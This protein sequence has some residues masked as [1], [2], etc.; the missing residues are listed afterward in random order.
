MISLT[1]GIFLLA[2]DPQTRAKVAQATL[3]PPRAH[4]ALSQR[5][6]ALSGWLWAKDK[7]SGPE[8]L[9]PGCV[10]GGVIAPG[11]GEQGP[12][13]GRYAPRPLASPTLL[14][15]VPVVHVMDS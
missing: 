13:L 11:S 12:Y 3:E 4:R 8:G 10:R 6:L 7:C 9:C 15:C 5:Q 2:T 14:A 1:P